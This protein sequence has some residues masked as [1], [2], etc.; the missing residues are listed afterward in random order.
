MTTAL[1]VYEAALHGGPASVVNEHGR[2]RPLPVHLWAGPAEGAD[3]GLLDRCSG[4]TLDVGCGPGRMTGALTD[5][6]VPALGI[7]VSAAAVRLT[8]QRG[9]LVLRRNVFDDIPGLGRWSHVLLADGNIGIG[10]DPVRLLRRCRELL[11]VGGTVLLDVEAPGAGLLVER[12]RIEHAVGSSGWFRWCWVSVDAL[13]S[14]AESAGLSVARVWL[15][16]GRWQA[17]LVAAP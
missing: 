15:T 2:Q 4:P 8:A 10:G 9:A 16:D 13:A 5:R 12:V 6:G 1:T 14:V 17:E 3:D 11:A 7:D